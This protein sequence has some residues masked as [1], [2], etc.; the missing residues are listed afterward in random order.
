METQCRERRRTLNSQAGTA[1]RFHLEPP[2]F[3]TGKGPLGHCVEKDS[4]TTLGL[5]RKA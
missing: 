2:R 4:E 1:R 3:I 5:N